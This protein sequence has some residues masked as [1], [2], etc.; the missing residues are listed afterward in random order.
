MSNASRNHGRLGDRLAPPSG[1]LP[2]S[3][4]DGVLLVLDLAGFSI[5]CFG[6]RR[7]TYGFLFVACGTKDLAKNNFPKSGS[8]RL[9]A[10]VPARE[11]L[12]KDDLHGF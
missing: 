1:C 12:I 5:G 9:G 7:Q 11:M 8:L 4:G 6:L 2:E 10:I 3:V